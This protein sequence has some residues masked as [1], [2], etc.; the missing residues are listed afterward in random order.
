MIQSHNCMLLEHI[1]A[2]L[3]AFLS[4]PSRSFS[5]FGFLLLY[6]ISDRFCHFLFGEYI[7]TLSRGA[8]IWTIFAILYFSLC[9]GFYLVCICFCVYWL[10][11]FSRYRVHSFICPYI[12]NVE[13]D[14]RIILFSTEC[15]FFLKKRMRLCVGAYI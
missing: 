10:Y 9:F 14:T 12:V 1:I 2:L 4:F 15:F 13:V 3:L 7:E 11:F 6:S 8:L 5:I